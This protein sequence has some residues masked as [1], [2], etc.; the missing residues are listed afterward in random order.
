MKTIF[1]DKIGDEKR[2]V[3]EREVQLVQQLDHPHIIHYIDVYE[4]PTVIHIV[5]LRLSM[6]QHNFVVSLFESLLYK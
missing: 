1:K 4:E 6:K 2:H 5:T 3:L